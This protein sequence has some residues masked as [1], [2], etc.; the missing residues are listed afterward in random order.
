MQDKKS[1]REKGHFL[2]RENRGKHENSN[3]ENLEKQGDPKKI[4]PTKNQKMSGKKISQNKRAANFAVFLIFSSKTKYWTFLDFLR[5]LAI[6]YF[7]TIFQYRAFLITY[8]LEYRVLN[9][10]PLPLPRAPTPQKYILQNQVS[11][12]IIFYNIPFLII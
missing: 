8:I 12:Y 11:N 2:I 9:Y 1:F 5:F 6:F 10:T 4:C 7:L 3:E